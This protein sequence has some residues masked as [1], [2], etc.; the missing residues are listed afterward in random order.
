MNTQGEGGNKINPMRPQSSST[1]WL[2]IK[3]QKPLA[4]KLSDFQMNHVQILSNK[5]E[6][7]QQLGLKTQ[8]SVTVN[9]E[10]LKTNS[11]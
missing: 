9:L 11:H 8:E 3:T 1:A 10:A 7:Q 6:R 5:F 2:Q 4:E